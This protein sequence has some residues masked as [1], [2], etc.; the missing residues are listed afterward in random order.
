MLT[1][2]PQWLMWVFAIVVVVALVL[3]FVVL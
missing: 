2:A 1:M 3:D